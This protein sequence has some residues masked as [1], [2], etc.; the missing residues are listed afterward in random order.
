MQHHS[1]A[2]MSLAHQIF[3]IFV[4]FSICDRMSMRCMSINFSTMKPLKI[5]FWWIT[6]K[7]S[8]PHF[9]LCLNN[10]G[11]WKHWFIFFKHFSL[12]QILGSNVSGVFFSIHCGSFISFQSI[13][14]ISVMTAV[15]FCFVAF[16]SLSF[17]NPNGRQYDFLRF[18]FVCSE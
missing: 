14:L 6:W 11:Y 4:I 13:E 18:I 8:I 5:F 1:V 15:F 7:W 9:S 3:Q 10:V 2:S 16:F 17:K 12:K